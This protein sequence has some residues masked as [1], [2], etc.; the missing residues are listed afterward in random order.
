M[1]KV[2][3]YDKALILDFNETEDGYLNIDACPI[4]RPGVFPYRTD[5]G[6]EMEAK[7]PEELFSA[8]TI[9]SANAKPITD[10]HPTEPVNA[11]NYGMYA[12]GMTHTDAAVKDNKVVVSFTITDSKMIDKIQSGKRELS[13]GFH[14]DV[15][16]EKGHYDGMQYDSVQRNMRINHI[17]V[18]ENGRAGS[19]VAI[20][21]DSAFMLDDEEVKKN[22]Q[23]GGKKMPVL[24]ID[25][26]DFEVDSAVE[27]HVNGLNSQIAKLEGERDGLQTQVTSL[28]TQLEEARE[29]QLTA[30]EM[31]EAVEARVKLLD[32]AKAFLGDS[33]EFKGKS[34]R[35]VKEAVITSIKKDA[36]MKDRSDDYV[37]AFYDSLTSVAN[38]KG[39][40]AGMNF[41]DAKDKDEEGKEELEKKKNARLNLNKKK[42]DN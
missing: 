33:F 34:D 21:A 16:R 39:F 19:E 23:T 6:V 18:V 10:D 36:D 24:K 37:N 30:D 4:T 17:A 27:S 8:S 42:E 41:S 1:T 7:L 38:S 13:I 26:K 3:R 28:N 25:N 32:S 20:R 31:D 29:G 22:K 5:S 15:T 40:T 14:A 11:A 12:K 2:Q 9:E 35:A